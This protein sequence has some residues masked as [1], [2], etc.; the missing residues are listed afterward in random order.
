MNDEERALAI[1]SDRGAIYVNSHFVYASGKHGLDYV[2]KDVVHPHTADIS[3]LCEM[4]AEHLVYRTD[5]IDSD[6]SI[7]IAPAT[8]GI[9]L[10]QWTAHHLTGMTKHDFLA[11]YAEKGT[12]PIED[13]EELGR[14]CFAETGSF[15]IRRGYERIVKGKGVVV[16]ED[17]L[18]TG[19]SVEEVIKAVK[20]AG[21][22][23]AV[24]A[25]LCNRGGVTAEKIGAPRLVSLIN[26]SMDA[27]EEG[28]CPLCR[29]GVPIDT[30]AG[31]GKDFLLRQ[32]S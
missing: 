11:V 4:L 9:V 31:H 14:D 20:T 16:V 1:F 22:R 15:V 10:S 5:V 25:A 30:R 26:V 2:A 13:P 28:E 24:V 7:V 18:N 3:R 17:V 6:V 23:V 8:A 32:K 19:G 29:A 27:Y 21:G 12:V